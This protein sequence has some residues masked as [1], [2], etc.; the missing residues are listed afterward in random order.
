MFP[1]QENFMVLKDSATSILNCLI[2]SQMKRVTN[3][4][5]LV[6]E[7]YVGFLSLFIMRPHSLVCTGCRSLF[8][9]QSCESRKLA[10]YRGMDETFTLCWDTQPRS[11]GT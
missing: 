6:R 7:M 3:E 9:G 4:F 2:I 10:C 5:L 8:A 11:F 1:T